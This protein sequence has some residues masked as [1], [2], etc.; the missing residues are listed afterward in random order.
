MS[1][2]RKLV[3]LCGVGN[4]FYEPC[5]NEPLVDDQGGPHRILPGRCL[6]YRPKTF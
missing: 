1:L 3:V 6:G 2:R 5:F 4:E